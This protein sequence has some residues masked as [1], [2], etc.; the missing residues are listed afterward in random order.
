VEVHAGDVRGLAVRV[1]ARIGALAASGEILVS[2]TVCDLVSGAGLQF[3]P[4][5][6]HALKGVP[7]SWELHAV[8]GP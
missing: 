4:R 7:G 8:S 6:T 2:R 3:V 1:G 5:G